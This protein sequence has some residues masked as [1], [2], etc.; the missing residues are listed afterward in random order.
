MHYARTGLPSP[1]TKQ[2]IVRNVEVV[3]VEDQQREGVVP[4]EPGQ[5]PVGHGSDHTT[6]GDDGPQPAHDAH[7]AVLVAL[8]GLLV[9]RRGPQQLDAEEAVLDGCQVGVRLHHHDVL[10]V[11]AVLGLGP[12]AEE[13][14][15]V[16]DGRDGE[17]QVV[18]LEPLGADEQQ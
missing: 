3:R 16:D 4:R 12:E 5:Q 14:R 10:H 17:G 8:V 6:H 18:V 1:R 2:E 13:Q 11:E 9:A 7:V 15:A